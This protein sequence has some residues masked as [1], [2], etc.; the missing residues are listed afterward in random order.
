MKQN[1]NLPEASTNAT[2]LK[3]TST[4]QPWVTPTFER[5]DLKKA[6]S[7]PSG[8]GSDGTVYS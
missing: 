3:A 6:L 1:S 2:E 8:S 5:E 7:S 4:P